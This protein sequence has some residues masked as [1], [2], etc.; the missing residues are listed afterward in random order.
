MSQLT[1]EQIQQLLEA[2]R[3]LPNRSWTKQPGEVQ[4]YQQLFDELKREPLIQPDARFSA[5]VMSRIDALESATIHSGTSG[6]LWVGVSISLLI[7]I[8][9]ITCVAWLLTD[10]GSVLAVMQPLKGALV[11]VLVSLLVIH[12]LDYKLIGE[13]SLPTRS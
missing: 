10:L 3:S 9:T 4:L 2:G 7:A 1:D 6:W 8:L 5:R 12:W 11:F 13:R